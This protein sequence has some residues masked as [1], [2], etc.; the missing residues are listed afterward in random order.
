LRR[1]TIALGIGFGAVGLA[2]LSAEP[3]VEEM[4][5]VLEFAL[6]VQVD[7]GMEIDEVRAFWKPRAPV[8]K[9]DEVE[10]RR[11]EIWV[12]SDFAELLND[13]NENERL[14]KDKGEIDDS[15]VSVTIIVKGS[16]KKGH[17]SWE[18]P[19]WVCRTQ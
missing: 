3:T 10:L 13:E 14:D 15:V 4:F 6:Q 5:P 12:P 1:W 9:Y 17:C 7:E 16:H 18:G 2:P 11:A 8:T 19:D